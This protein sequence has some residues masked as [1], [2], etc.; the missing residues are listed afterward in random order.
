MA[1]NLGD[2]KL[3]NVMSFA[4]KNLAPQTLP[5]YIGRLFRS[6]QAKYVTVKGAGMA[7]AF[8]FMGLAIVLNYMIAYKHELKYEKIRKYH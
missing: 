1:E 6:Y 7:P 4:K 5:L 2:V 8:H 3:R